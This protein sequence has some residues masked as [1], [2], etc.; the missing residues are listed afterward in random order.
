MPAASRHKAPCVPI[1][2]SSNARI[3]EIPGKKAK[4]VL[5]C[6]RIRFVRRHI[7]SNREMPELRN[8]EPVFD[9][10]GGGHTDRRHILD[11]V[12]QSNCGTEMPSRCNDPVT[13]PECSSTALQNRGGCLKTT[14]E[15]WSDRGMK[16]RTPQ[17]KA[18]MHST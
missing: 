6:F 16:R 9:I 14:N 13:L 3:Y 4:L 11:R 2:R 8:G 5:A 1:R 17:A 18:A 12:G 10:A 15:L 7:E